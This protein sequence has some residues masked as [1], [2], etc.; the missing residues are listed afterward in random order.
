M[1]RPTIRCSDIYRD[2]INDLFRSTNLDRNQIIRAALFS[3]AYSDL[4]QGIIKEHLKKDVTPPLPVWG[5]N[6]NRLWM[7]QDPEI[8]R[9]ERD[10]NAIET[11]RVETKIDNG[12]T[13]RIQYGGFATITSTE[14][15]E[16]KVYKKAG[17]GISIQI[18][19]R[20]QSC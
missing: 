3:A 13:K 11:R 7:E 1:Y 12:T 5:S 14:R 17:G 4:F 15:R 8:K 10:V 6:D 19:T 20:N 2:Y 16:G 18:G 9:E